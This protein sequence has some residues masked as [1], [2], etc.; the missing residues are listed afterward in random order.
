MTEPTHGP[1]DLGEGATTNPARPPVGG[2]SA[3]VGGAPVSDARSRANG[4]P[5]VDAAPPVADVVP[6]DVSVSG[7]G[8][9]LAA[10]G[11]AGV[12]PAVSPVAEAGQVNPCCQAITFDQPPGWLVAMT[13]WRG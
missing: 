12:D 8:V 4:V 11:M 9:L 2:P 1:D 10:A 7:D 3:G 6:A 13:W 5:S